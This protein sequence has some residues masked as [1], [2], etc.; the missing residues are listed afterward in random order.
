MPYRKTTADQ[1]GVERQRADKPKRKEC[2]TSTAA[3]S[4]ELRVMAMT[5]LGFVGGVKYLEKVAKTNPAAYLAFL[6]KVV[7]VKNDTEVGP[8]ER[9]F[10][11]RTIQV[12]AT[13][14]PGVINSPVAG[15]IMA[16]RLVANGGEVI[17]AEEVP[18][19]G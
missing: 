5:S 8:G 15:H 16:P 4:R 14:T 9:T 17:D 19:H 7:A 18:P 1:P 6:A 12:V 2:P 10:V 13:P 3:L 11:V